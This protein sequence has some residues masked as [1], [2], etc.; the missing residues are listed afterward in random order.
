MLATGSDVL[1]KIAEYL[2]AEALTDSVTVMPVQEFA[3]ADLS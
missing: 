1:E 2:A 3:V